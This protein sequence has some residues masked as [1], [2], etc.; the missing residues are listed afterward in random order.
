[1]EIGSGN[2]SG[3]SS[4]EMKLGNFRDLIEFC[5]SLNQLTPSEVP[6]SLTSR[7]LVCINICELEFSFIDATSFA[8]LTSVM[9]ALA[10]T[11]KR[12]VVYTGTF[13]IE[14]QNQMFR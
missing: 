6:Q 2:L 12:E 10:Y 3:F 1:M 4:S 14:G 5:G 13:K 11:V 9:Y 8:S 7:S